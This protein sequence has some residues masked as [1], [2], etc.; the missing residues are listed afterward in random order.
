M[1]TCTIP[2]Q[3]ILSLNLISL[4][5]Q[6]LLVVGEATDES[7]K[8]ESSLAV[9]REK[10][11][12]LEAELVR[13]KQLEAD[14]DSKAKQARNTDEGFQPYGPEP[15][16]DFDSPS[17]EE[18][19]D[20][21]QHYRLRETQSCEEITVSTFPT[22]PD[23]GPSRSLEDFSSYSKS[24]MHEPIRQSSNGLYNYFPFWPLTSNSSGGSQGNSRPVITNATR[25]LGNS[26]G[27]RGR[28]STKIDFAT[29]LSGHRGLN[30]PHSKNSN[31]GGRNVRLMSAH[32]G[33]GY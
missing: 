19:E 21:D 2:Q 8:I 1:T 27:S 33:V 3:S 26:G 5:F 25:A 11:M 30:R 22:I 13:L 4:P 23:I 16:E 20:L 10:L 28:N 14:L 31:S 15:N 7:C 32:R 29:G 17:D 9:V 18:I 6:T 24:L 12:P